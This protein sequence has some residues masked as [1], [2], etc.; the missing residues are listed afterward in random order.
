MTN[1]SIAAAKTLTRRVVRRA[2]YDL[3][4]LTAGMLRAQ[5]AQMQQAATV[6][7]VGANVGQFAELARDLGFRGKIVSFE[8]GAA[9]FALLRDRAE[10]SNDS[11][12]ARNVALSDRAGQAKLNVS[13][14]SV[15]SS[16]LNVQGLHLDAAPKSVTAYTEEV[17]VATLD[18]QVAEL[19]TESPYFLK[20]DVQGLE[21]AVLRGAKTA[22]S[23]TGAVRVEVSF[24]P[25]YEGQSRWLEVCDHIQSHGFVVEYVEPGYEDKSGRMLQADFLFVRR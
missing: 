22:L 4:P 25:L 18:D 5:K 14:N 2:G 9:A 16:L 24:R 23:R 7:D 19:G 3:V 13:E 17:V 1:R 10:R 6:L 21:L 12:I 20:L 15:S 11:W 8:P